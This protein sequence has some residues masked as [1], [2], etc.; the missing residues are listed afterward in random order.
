MRDEA[1]ENGAER[2]DRL[3]G[4]AELRG[5]SGVGAL[6]QRISAWAE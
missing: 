2:S 5:V 1:A 4:G 6:D 3:T